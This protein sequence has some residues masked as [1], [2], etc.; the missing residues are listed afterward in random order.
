MN[1]NIGRTADFD[2]G[3]RGKGVI[4]VDF[5]VGEIRFKVRVKFIDIHK[6]II[7]K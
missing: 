5:G 6:G 4:L 3:V 1:K 7:A 2:G